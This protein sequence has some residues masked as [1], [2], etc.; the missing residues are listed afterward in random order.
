[1]RACGCQ[2]AVNSNPPGG[3]SS[4]RPL[5]A[6]HPRHRGANSPAFTSLKSEWRGAAD[7]ARRALID[8][9]AD[10][11]ASRILATAL[12]LDDDPDGALAAWNNVGEPIIDLVNVTGLERTRTCVAARA[13]AIAP[14][15]SADAV[16]TPCGAAAS[17]RTARQR[18]RPASAI[19]PVNVGARKSMPL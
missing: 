10:P 6:P 16:G 18:R 8:D 15:G 1:M 12:Y 7:D 17:R 5:S 11:L 14:E 19:G 3:C 4:S 13:M 9:P 2:A